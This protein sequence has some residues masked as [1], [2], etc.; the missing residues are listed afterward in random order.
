MTSRPN[1]QEGANGPF[2]LWNFWCYQEEE[3]E[4]H[5]E[6]FSN[7]SIWPLL[8]YLPNYLRYEPSWWEHYQRVNQRFADKVLE[9]AHEA[10]L[11]WVHDYQ[12]M[13]LPALLKA[14]APQL[15]VGFFLHTPFPAH[16]I[17][18][19]HPHGRELVAGM[20]GADLIGFHTFGY[21]RHFSGR[22]TYS[23]LVYPPAT[24]VIF[25]A[26]HSGTR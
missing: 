23:N 4:A 15:R 7:S 10:E 11:I 18:R 13:L 24:A 17:F 26:V 3:A 8:H 2:E 9:T 6:G 25:Y 12:L 14:M 20:L 21:L 16:E 22:G 5:Y 19:C 1:H